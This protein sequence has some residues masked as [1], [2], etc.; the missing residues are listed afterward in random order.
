VESLKGLNCDWIAGRLLLEIQQSRKMLCTSAM[1]ALKIHFLLFCMLK[2]V[3][4]LQAWALPG[5]SKVGGGRGGEK[6]EN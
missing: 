6:L 1:T 2:S 4:L 5:L 3:F